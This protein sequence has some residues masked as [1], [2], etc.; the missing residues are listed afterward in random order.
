M[1]E[2]QIRRRDALRILFG[3]ALAL[4]S[5]RASRASSVVIGSKN[6]TEQIIM[7]EL[8]AQQIE[9]HTGLRA[10][11]R[12]NL[13]GTFLCHQAMLAGQMDFYVEYTGAALTAILGGKPSGDA[14]AVY[15]TVHD[16]YRNRFNLEVGP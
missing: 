6:F 8:L 4:T 10:D 5:C 7:G 11:R 13:G 1:M 12:L 9:A 16:G 15:G 14:A 3:G 2:A